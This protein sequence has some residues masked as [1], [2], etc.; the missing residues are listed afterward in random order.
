MEFAIKKGARPYL[1]A[2][3]SSSCLLLHI[4]NLSAL[5]SAK[6][7]EGS[8]IG[9]VGGGLG[10]GH[11]SASLPPHR[12]ELQRFPATSA[13]ATG[14]IKFFLSLQPSLSS[15]SLPAFLG[16]GSQTSCMSKIANLADKLRK[17]VKG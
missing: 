12:V 17:K 4:N 9:V 14:T 11:R 8:G 5:P 3:H 16:E 10:D 2:A 15:A 7:G 6:F 13:A 1:P